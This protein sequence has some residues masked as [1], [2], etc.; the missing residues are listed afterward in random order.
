MTE[1]QPID[2]YPKDNR[3]R[4][5]WCP[6]WRN[7]YIVTWVVPWGDDNKPDPAQGFFSHFGAGGSRLNER[8]THWAD[9]PAP[10]VQ[11]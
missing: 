1:W 8:P 5:V 9:L 10:P 4:L 2:T 3:A 7:I 6:A 11:P